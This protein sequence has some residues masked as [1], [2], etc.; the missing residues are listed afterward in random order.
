MGRMYF[1]RTASGES[2]PFSSAEIREQIQSG[3]ATAID[4]IRMEGKEKWIL[5][6]QVPQLQK[7]V[8]QQRSADVRR[9][10]F[11][12]ESPF[13]FNENGS[14]ASQTDSKDIALWNPTHVCTFAILCTVPFGAFLFASNWKTIGVDA[15][16]KRSMLWCYAGIGLLLFTN[17]L[18]GNEES[19]LFARL[20]HLTFFCLWWYFEYLP[21]LAK[22]KQ[23]FGESYRQKSLVKPVGISLVCLFVGMLFFVRPIENTGNQASA[24]NTANTPQSNIDSAAVMLASIWFGT[25]TE[26]SSSSRLTEQFMQITPEYVSD[27][28][29]QAV[30]VGQNTLDWPEANF[31]FLKMAS[32]MPEKNKTV[33]NGLDGLIVKYYSDVV[34]GFVYNRSKAVYTLFYVKI[35]KVEVDLSQLVQG[36]VDTDRLTERLSSQGGQIAITGKNW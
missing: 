33:V 27:R 23:T 15:K 11:E 16:A 4:E 24:S 5:L 31:R 8:E 2:G 32:I 21:M 25:L 7:F 22:V 29:M 1:L 36:N 18:P 20:T 35:G 12:D 13:H 34:F 6:T 10:G 14:K 26:N 17:L 9:E 3:R 30:R 28:M 19:F